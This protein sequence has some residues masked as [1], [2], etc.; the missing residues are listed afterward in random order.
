MYRH[1]AL[2]ISPAYL[3]VL[4]E[5]WQKSRACRTP[6]IYSAESLGISREEI[7]RI[8]GPCH[9]LRFELNYYV[10]LRK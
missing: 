4:Q 10:N 5:E 8:N 9:Y 3:E 6:H 1:F 2:H 7:R